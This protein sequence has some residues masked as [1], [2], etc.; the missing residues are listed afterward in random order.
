VWGNSISPT[1]FKYFIEKSF[2]N[3]QFF[4]KGKKP[5]C[6][7]KGLG[8]G[9]KKNQDMLNSNFLETQPK[10]KKVEWTYCVPTTPFVL[11]CF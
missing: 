5:P 8:G 4:D 1:P 9:G 11:A 7:G 3:L 2:P 10:R 6:L